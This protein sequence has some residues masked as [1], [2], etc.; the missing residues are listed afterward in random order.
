MTLASL[1][2]ALSRRRSVTSVADTFASKREER[3][4]RSVHCDGCHV[5]SQS[6]MYMPNGGL[7][8]RRCAGRVAVWALSGPAEVEPQHAPARVESAAFRSGDLRAD[9][10][11]RH[12]R[13]EESRS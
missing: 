4:R 11:I 8:C 13:A 1:L 5:W 7:Y 12:A 3:M 2:R 10:G 9:L 6:L